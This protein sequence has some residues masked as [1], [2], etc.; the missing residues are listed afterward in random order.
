MEKKRPHYDLAV[1]KRQMDAVETMVLTTS[2]RNGIKKARM[3]LQQAWQVMQA[4]SLKNFH[5]SMTVYG[6]HKVWQD[7]YF[8]EWQ[9]I[10]L[11]I[12]FQRLDDYFIISFKE[13]DDE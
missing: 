13:R 2:A 1:I 11:Y 12:K 7:V 10:A 3:S 6:D 5:K 4:L 9:G 8:S